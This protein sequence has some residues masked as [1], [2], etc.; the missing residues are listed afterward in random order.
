MMRKI[1]CFFC[2][3]FCLFGL[4]AQTDSSRRGLMAD[5]Q[6]AQSAQNNLRKLQNSSGKSDSNSDSVTE[7]YESV[8][9]ADIIGS[10]QMAMA[11]ADYMVTAGDIYTLGYAVG[12]NAVTYTIAVDSSYRIRV[13]NLAVLDGSGKT[14]TGLRRQVEEIVSKNYPMS[15]VQFALTSPA[16][17]TVIVSGEVK[18][19]AE[20][21]AWALTRLSSVL[22]KMLTPYSSTRNIE[23]TSAS[24]KKKTY[25]LFKAARD[26]DMSQNPY[27]RPGDVISV[28]RAER[29]VTVGG[30]V[31]RPG[32]YELLAG[33]NLTSLL[34]VY[35][36]GL[37]PQADRS[38]VELTRIIDGN[39]RSGTKLYLN[40]DS[41]PDFELKPYDKVEVSSFSDLRPVM[42]VEGAVYTSEDDGT[43]LETSARKAVRFESGTN[44]AYFVRKNSTWFSTTSDTENAY[45]IRRGEVIPL[46]LNKILYDSG[47][48]TELAVE[49]D[50][51]L[52]VPFK[53]YFVS[54]AG[55]VN[56]PG[57]YPYIPDRTYEYYIGLAG[58][59]IKLQNMGNSV[60]IVDIDGKKLG[61]TDVI[62]PECTITAKTNSPVY[63]IN[64]FAPI[65]TTI[66]TAT[67]TV[68][69]IIAFTAK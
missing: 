27:L 65:I 51:V 41:S 46:N 25:D 58:G 52:R 17:F 35:G 67:S 22:D 6:N 44:Y 63:Y 57:R 26:G 29:K 3:G 32:T 15:G 24:G 21:E 50:D 61:T 13:A 38:S 55:S 45:I 60:A 69:S 4:A 68:L 14:Y 33:E 64:V 10:P 62:T 42:F 39:D 28:P 47:Y 19:T 9:T 40:L 59:F 12:T 56:S 37:V 23:I 43:E 34:D 48:T 49:A 2:V 7:E 16:V 11:N 18:N 20:R 30:A 8:L 31:E 36:G 66:L 1:T 53:Q 5:F 54:V